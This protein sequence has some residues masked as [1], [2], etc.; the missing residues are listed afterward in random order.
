MEEFFYIGTQVDEIELLDLLLK[1]YH[2]LDF[3]RVLSVEQFLELLMKA[4]EGEIKD[5]H[6]QEWLAVIPV[7]SLSGNFMNFDEYY[8]LATGKNIDMRPADVIM[9]EID[10]KHAQAGENQ[11]GT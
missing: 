7:M 10:R 3:M 5:R 2:S 8:D 11:N 9:A 1:R 4:I 6:R